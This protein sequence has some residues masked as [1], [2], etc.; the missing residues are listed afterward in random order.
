MKVTNRW[1]KFEQKPAQIWTQ[2]FVFAQ[3]AIDLVIHHPSLDSTVPRSLEILRSYL[4]VGS[5]LTENLH[6]G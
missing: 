6:G 3:Q 4:N 2:V 5:S 1:L